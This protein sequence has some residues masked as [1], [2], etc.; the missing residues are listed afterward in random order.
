M[1]DKT[2]TEETITVPKGSADS[3]HVH[4]LYNAVHIQHIRQISGRR[5]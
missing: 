3:L 2:R 4:I 5:I 1:N